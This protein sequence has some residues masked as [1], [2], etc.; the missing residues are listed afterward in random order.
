MFPDSGASFQAAKS[1]YE[2]R[3]R[4]SR[5]GNCDVLHANPDTKSAKTELI[6]LVQ[7]IY[8]AEALVLYIELRT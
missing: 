4:L 5:Y 6:R 8:C 1:V 7:F 2:P 3:Y